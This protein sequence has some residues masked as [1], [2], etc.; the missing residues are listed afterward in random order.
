MNTQSAFDAGLAPLPTFFSASQV[1]ATITSTNRLSNF[2]DFSRFV[3]PAF[4]TMTSFPALGSSSYHG[5]SVDFQRRMSHGVL[6]R[7]NYTWSHNI[8]NATN[9]LFSSLVNPRRP[10]DW[11]NLA[12][13]RGNS[14]LD[15]RHKFALSWVWDLPKLTTDNGFLKAIAH[16]WEWTGTYLAQSGQPISIL[17]DTDSNGNGDAAGDR[18][19]FNPGGTLNVGSTVN[20][21]CVGAGGATSIAPMTLANGDP[22][23]ASSAVAG[24]VADNPNARYV[25]AQLGAQSTVGRNSFRSPGVNIWNMGMYKDTKLTER[26]SFQFR[27]TA[28]N[29]FNHRNFS[30]AQPT[31]L[32]TGVIIGTTNNAL[33]STY[34]NVDAGSLFLNAKQFNGGSRIME[35]GLKLIF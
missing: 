6:L 21:V 5:A 4:S 2:E 1:P 19:I 26:F 30:L 7:A 8:D 24:Y 33:S 12:L 15:V 20:F 13:D 27:A 23:C 35:L 16:G 32:Q 34:A 14:T 25:Q 31:V 18:A 28:Q 9:E 11:R 22:G 29:I 17:S 3:D 10:Q